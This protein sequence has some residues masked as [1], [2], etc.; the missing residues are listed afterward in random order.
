MGFT[1]GLMFIQSLVNY[2]EQL[3]SSSV[4]TTARFWLL[5]FLFSTVQKESTQMICKLL[6]M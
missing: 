2:V 4:E 3:N 6:N 5:Y 1:N